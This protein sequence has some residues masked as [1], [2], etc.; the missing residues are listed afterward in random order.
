LRSA[1]FGVGEAAPSSAAIRGGD[2]LERPANLVG[3]GRGGAAR[4]LHHMSVF[5]MRCSSF[6]ATPPLTRRPAGNSSRALLMDFEAKS[7]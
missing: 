4:D 3:G 5:S 7:R 6:E 2:E 1:G